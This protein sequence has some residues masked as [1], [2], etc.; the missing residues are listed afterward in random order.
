[1]VWFPVVE[2][3]LRAASRR[4]S[5]YRVR[6]LALMGVL[7]VFAWIVF[8]LQR[9]SVTF[10]DLSGGRQLFAALSIPASIFCVMV[11]VFATSDSIS[12]EKRE[13]TLGLLFLTDL[14][15]YDVIWGKL[16][17][18]S[19]N[20]FYALIAVLPV[21]GVP[22]LAGGVTI[23]QFVKLALALLTA[24]VWSM[25]VGIMVS[26]A[27]RD[28]RQSAFY[29]LFLLGLFSIV[30]LGPTTAILTAV[31]PASFSPLIYWSSVAAMWTV[32]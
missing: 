29:T 11:G 6:V 18:S 9:S 12:A 27:H 19:L 7:V 25:A 31:R 22:I 23:L 20:G 32:T 14:S 30:P 3:E 5:T 1:M 24:V 28:E 17:A 13:G 16:V 4:R 26:T 8:V 21:L 10:G 2:R 15:G